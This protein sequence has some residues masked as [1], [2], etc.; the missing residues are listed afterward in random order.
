MLSRVARKKGLKTK[1]L[2]PRSPAT[3][4]QWRSGEPLPRHP[5]FRRRPLARLAEEDP[6]CGR[7]G[8]VA[9]D[10]LV[11]IPRIPVQPLRQMAVV[12]PAIHASPLFGREV[13]EGL[14][15]AIRYGAERAALLHP[16]VVNEPR[17]P[18][19][20]QPT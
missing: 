16:L 13:F 6:V 11:R 8:R 4:G 15:T 20:R 3:S 17:R 9:P 7:K 12:E 18:H 10:E 14:R 19:T 2:E 1:D 5:L